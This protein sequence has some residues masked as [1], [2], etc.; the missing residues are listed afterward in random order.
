[1]ADATESREHWRAAAPGWVQHGGFVRETTEPV[2]RAMIERAAPVPGERWL[3]VACGVGDPALYVARALDG[4]GQVVVTD[5]VLEMA[6]EARAVIRETG[7]GARVGAVVATAEGMPFAGAFDGL[8]CR[9]GAMFFT[10]P[11]PA[12]VA[13]RQTLNPGGR[14]VFAVWAERERNVFFRQVNDVVR[15]RFPDAPVP[16]PDEPHPFRFSGPGELAELLRGAGW[17]PVGEGRLPFVMAAR[18]TVDQFWDHLTGLNAEFR[19]LVNEL[20]PEEARGLRE[21]ITD[22]VAPFFKSGSMR[23]PAEARLVWGRAPR[24]VRGAA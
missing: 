3:D 17:T 8:T 16:D 2:S 15:A 14:G 11:V 9:F 20:P 4:G 23:F 18:R 6:A 5:L 7:P 1:M 12:L 22:R 24:Q 19:G 21:E 10:E 13:L